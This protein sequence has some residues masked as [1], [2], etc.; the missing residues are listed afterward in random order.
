MQVNTRWVPVLASH[1]YSRSDLQF[2]AC[3][4]VMAGT[5]ILAKGLAEGKTAWTGVGNYHSRT[6]VH[7]QSWWK[8]VYVSYQIFNSVIS[9]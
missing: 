2:D 1:D 5:W 4:N 3:R 9:S 8:S 7:N 6:P